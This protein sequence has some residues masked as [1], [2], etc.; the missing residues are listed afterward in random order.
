MAGSE[1]SQIAKSVSNFGS[2]V[3]QFRQSASQHNDSVKNILKDVHSVFKSQSQSISN[4]SDSIQSSLSD[5]QD[6]VTGKINST[7]SLLENS[8]QVQNMMMQQLGMMSNILKQV[9]QNTQWMAMNGGGQNKLGGAGGM[10]TALDIAKDT[11]KSKSAKGIGKKAGLLKF[12]G[13]MAAIGIAGYGAYKAA[14]YARDKLSGIGASDGEPLGGGPGNPTGEAPGGGFTPRAASQNGSSS[15]AMQFFTSKHW[16]KEQAAGIVGNLQYESK[17]FS[18]DVISGKDKGDGGKAVGIA[19]WHPHR[20]AIFK[21]IKG[22]N[23][24]DATFTEQLDFVQWELMNSHKSAGD[25][26]RNAKTAQE[27]ANVINQHYEISANRNNPNA[28]DVKQRIANSVS[29]AGGGDQ[30][31]KTTSTS[32]SVPQQSAA[33]TG[34]PPATG[35]VL[36]AATAAVSTATVGA[37]QTS[38][39]QTGDQLGAAAQ[40]QGAVP[41]QKEEAIPGSQQAGGDVIQ[42][43]SGIRNQKIDDKL[44]GVLKSAAAAAGVTVHVTSGGQPAAGEGGSRTGSTRHDHGMAADLDLYQGGQRLSPK[45]APD[46]FKKF[47]GAAHSAGATGIGAGEGYMGSD[48]GR[49][50]VGFGS[51]AIW[52][53][54]GK[55]ANAADWLKE[56]VGSGT[57]GSPENN[58]ALGNIGQMGAGQMG[59]G[60]L[61]QMMMGG[62]MPIEGRNLNT[63][64]MG[65]NPFQML[66][67]MIGGG[68]GAAIGSLVGMGANLLG[69]MFGGQQEEEEQ[70]ALVP[71]AQSRA[72]NINQNAAQQAALRARAAEQGS[73]PPEN[74]LVAAADGAQSQKVGTGMDAETTKFFGNEFAPSWFA[75]LKQ[76]YPHDLANVRF[77]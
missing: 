44:L 53:A 68:K 19:Q 59:H 54:G 21:Q 35:A 67:G 25:A 48:G 71:S 23:V 20:Q 45:T 74:Q 11:I 39:P 30:S 49:I 60:A 33:A 57:G 17:N 66:G 76:A 26:L 7:N 6:Q 16:S 28:A 46:V 56:T 5:S 65:G 64:G 40:Q 10:G 69:K 50:H 58:G 62:G 3:N 55:G 15:E 14:D 8:I 32:P 18:A 43:Q 34:I 37:Q 22:K 70:A 1:L 24:A 29:L 73:K 9:A 36:S 38:T 31:G 63:M 52:G 75:Q 12:G 2:T 77:A 72:S 4:L 41:I 47:V 42:E 13:I 61:G 51:S 27:A